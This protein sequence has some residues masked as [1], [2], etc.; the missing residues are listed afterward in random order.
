MEQSKKGADVLSETCVLPSL[1]VEATRQALNRYIGSTRSSSSQSLHFLR[2]F[3]VVPAVS[4]LVGMP[5]DD[6][7]WRDAFGDDRYLHRQK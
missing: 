2:R 7:A 3:T 5:G 6:G 1:E 4:H